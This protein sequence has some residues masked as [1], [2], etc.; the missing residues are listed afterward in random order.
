MFVI[1]IV[2]CS[3]DRLNCRLGTGDCRFECV[4]LLGMPVTIGLSSKPKNESNFGV[5]G[6]CGVFWVIFRGVSPT[7]RQR[8]VLRKMMIQ[9]GN[10]FLILMGEHRC[11]AGCEHQLRRRG[12]APNADQIAH[13]IDELVDQIFQ[14]KKIWFRLKIAN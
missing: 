2:D 9:I 10:Q 4:G 1:L 3:S 11:V 8:G 12:A 5:C 13:L 6:V 14:S 7:R